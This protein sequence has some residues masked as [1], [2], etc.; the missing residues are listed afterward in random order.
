M[1]TDSPESEIGRS[2]LDQVETEVSERGKTVFSI[3]DLS[4]EFDVTLRTLRFYEDK[5]LVNPARRGTTRLYSR[6]DRARLKL[7]Q[8]GKRVGF[9]LDQIKDMLALYDLRGGQAPQLKVALSRFEEQISLLKQQRLDID[10]AIGELQRTCDV[11]SGML[12]QKEAEEV[13]LPTE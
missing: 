1:D 12:K 10:Q 2:R 8:M 3:G 5:G 13:V 9:S 6:R 7:V 4:Q 11:V